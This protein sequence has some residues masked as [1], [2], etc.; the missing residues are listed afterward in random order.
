MKINNLFFIHD[1]FIFRKQFFQI[2]NMAYDV[3]ASIIGQLQSD[4]KLKTNK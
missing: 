2:I 1:E 4:L 3:R